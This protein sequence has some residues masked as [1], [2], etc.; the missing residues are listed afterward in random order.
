MSLTVRRPRHAYRSPTPVEQPDQVALLRTVVEQLTAER[1]QARR[2][3]QRWGE[4]A[5]A[6]ETTLRNLPAALA[7][8]D[9]LI[10]SLYAEREEARAEAAALRAQ[11]Q[12]TTE[13]KDGTQ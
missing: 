6:A 10:R 1:D 9:A 2:A 4:R 12:P 8:P 3:A 7:N 13:P 11:L 5:T